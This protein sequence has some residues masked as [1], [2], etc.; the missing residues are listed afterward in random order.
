MTDYWKSIEER[1]HTESLLH[2]P[3]NKVRLLLKSYLNG[4]LNSLKSDVQDMVLQGFLLTC[5]GKYLDMYGAELGVPRENTEE[6]DS[7]RQRLF[8]IISDYLSVGYLKK[9]GNI[10]YTKNMLDDNIRENMTSNNPY[11]NNR[12]A[13]IPG[14]DNSLDFV[15]NDTITEDNIVT[16]LKGW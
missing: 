4:E 5:T 11:L 15:T 3:T 6:D 13:V 1:L 16:Y 12:Y 8:N 7:Y 14:N 2:Y 9:M 10:I